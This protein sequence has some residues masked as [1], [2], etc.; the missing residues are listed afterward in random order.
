MALLKQPLA[1]ATNNNGKAGM[2]VGQKIKNVLKDLKDSQSVMMSAKY[3]LTFCSLTLVNSSK[4]RLK[5]M[6]SNKVVVSCFRMGTKLKEF[7]RHTT[8]Q[9]T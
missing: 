2:M 3:L 7:T 5:E 9:M 8:K 4:H 1:D 6:S